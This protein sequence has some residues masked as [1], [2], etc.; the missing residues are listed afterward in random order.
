MIARNVS[1]QGFSSSTFKHWIFGDTS[2]LF[3]ASLLG[4]KYFMSC[5]KSISILLFPCFIL[6]LL[7]YFGYIPNVIFTNDSILIFVWRTY[8]I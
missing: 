6:F 1:T 3:F 8:F 2:V 4:T 5:S 7:V